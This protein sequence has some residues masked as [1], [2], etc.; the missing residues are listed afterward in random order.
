MNLPNFSQQK[1]IAFST[2]AACLFSLLINP[3]FCQNDYKPGD[4][5]NLGSVHRSLYGDTNSSLP[6]N[7]ITNV[8][9]SFSRLQNE[10]GTRGSTGG[11]ISGPDITAPSGG[12]YGSGVP[13]NFLNTRSIPWNP[14]DPVPFGSAHRPYVPEDDQPTLSGAEVG[15]TYGARNAA[16]PG[17]PASALPAAA[18]P[19]Y[20]LSVPSPL[21]GEE[22]ADLREAPKPT[23]HAANSQ[24]L[25]S[26]PLAQS[27]APSLISD[28]NEPAT[29]IS[30]RSNRSGSGNILARA[31]HW[32]ASLFSANK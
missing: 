21:T 3:V 30:N 2:L 28:Q 29:P 13:S 5:I 27:R 11:G 26:T 19:A 24:G 10:R 25:G 17:L 6:G 23:E 18:V 15:T 12:S 4:P 16:A 32:A 8:Q 20:P 31:M 7:T 1:K 22:T 14:G 9:E